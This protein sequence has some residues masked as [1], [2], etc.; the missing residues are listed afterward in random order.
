MPRRPKMS[1]RA[2]S[3]HQKRIRFLTGL[4]LSIIIVATIGLF[5]LA[6]RTSLA[7]H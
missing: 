7:S 1:K 4:A 3:P 5:L 2:P 6:N